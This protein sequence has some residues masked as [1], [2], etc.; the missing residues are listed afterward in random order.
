MVDMTYLKGDF[1]GFNPLS[2]MV[3][4]LKLRTLF[5]F[6]SKINVE[7]GVAKW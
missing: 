3:N 6:Y 4:A 2:S 1:W 5:S 7:R